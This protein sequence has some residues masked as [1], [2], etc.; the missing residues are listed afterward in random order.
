MDGA[1]QSESLMSN[2]INLRK[3]E[4][5]DINEMFEWRNHPDIRKNFFNQEMI[6]WD[7]HEKW[8]MAKLEDPDAAVY[9]AYYK[10]LF[11]SHLLK[12]LKIVPME[13]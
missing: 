12:I 4:I 13:N 5:T 1:Y 7:E 8:F 2:I 3:V 6:S 11:A 9:M 10:T